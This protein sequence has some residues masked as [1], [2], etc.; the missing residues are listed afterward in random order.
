M[1]DIV[2]LDIETIPKSMPNLDDP[3]FMKGTE[4]LLPLP[5]EVAA[6]CT[7]NWNAEAKKRSLSNIDCHLISL[8]YAINDG[9]VVNIFEAFNENDLILKLIDSDLMDIMVSMNPQV[10]AYNALAFDLP[11]IATKLF[12][13]GYNEFV[14]AIPYQEPPYNHT[15]VFDPMKVFPQTYNEHYMTQSRMA[16]YLGI[17]DH[18]E[19]DGSMV[20]DYHT[21]GKYEEIIKYN[22]EDVELLR[23]ICKRIT[24]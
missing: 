13:Y 9:S 14:A 5:Q 11:V 23:K 12:K 7:D 22:N 4:S 8:S 19:M 2:Y 17:D 24:I 1:R 10:C 18:S 6:K 20:Y 3:Q 21:Q 15:K 16:E